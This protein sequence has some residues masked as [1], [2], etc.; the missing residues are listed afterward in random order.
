MCRRNRVHLRKTV[1]DF[2]S[3]HDELCDTSGITGPPTSER[4][5]LSGDLC[6]WATQ[7]TVK[8]DLNMVSK[9]SVP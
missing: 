1:E 7:E 9:A 2:S 6:G 3:Y 5:T 4:P 8:S